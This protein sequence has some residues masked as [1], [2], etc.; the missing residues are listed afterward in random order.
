MLGR[1]TPAPDTRRLT[2]PGTGIVIP[3]TIRR[4]PLRS[5]YLLKI[6]PAWL[7]AFCTPTAW[8][9]SAMATDLELNPAAGAPEA[10]DR[11]ASAGAAPATATNIVLLGV[12]ALLLGFVGSAWATGALSY[13]VWW[14]T[15]ADPPSVACRRPGAG[16]R[17]RRGWSPGLAARPGCTSPG[18]RST[19]GRHRR[20]APLTIDT[21]T[22]PD[23]RDRVT[24][25]AEDASFRNNRAEP[26]SSYVGQHAA[27]TDGRLAPYRCGRGTNLAA[28]RSVRRA[29]V[30][31]GH[32]GWATAQP[33][34]R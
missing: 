21:T 11:D 14:L 2:R 16:A 7:R 20:D 26:A 4:I 9:A 23:G 30:R 32:A 25:E 34:S 17:A 24:V 1:G 12:V 27:E 3:G 31:R 6:L 18:R 22:L 15:N 29:R 28:A 5:D 8:L 13:G 10:G 19:A 33:P